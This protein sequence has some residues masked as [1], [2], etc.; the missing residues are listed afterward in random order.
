M[1]EAPVEKP[2]PAFV[3]RASRSVA[4]FEAC[5]PFRN[6]VVNHPMYQRMTTRDNVVVFMEHHVY[7]VWDFMCLLKALQRV[8]TCVDVPWVPQGDPQVRRFVNQIVLG[9]ESDQVNGGVRSHYEM[10]IEAMSLAEADAQTPE[11]FVECIREGHLLHRA[12]EKAGVPEA[13]REFVMTTMDIV[14]MNRPHAIAAAFTI[15][16][17]ELIPEMFREIVGQIGHP[18]LERFVEYLDRHIEVDS[19]EHGPA[20]RRLLEMLCE[21]HADRWHEATGVAIQVLRARAALWT[22]V[23]KALS[24]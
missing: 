21:D 7:A 3:N 16:R 2:D 12:F 5:E 23:E 18:K 24:T 20:S 11:A 17:E 4:L 13:A 6:R 14:N 10:Y 22:A 1:I 15:G 9:E 19:G 8:V